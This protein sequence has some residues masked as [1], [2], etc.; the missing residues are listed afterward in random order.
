MT[1]PTRTWPEDWDAQ[2]AGAGCPFCAQGRIE[3]NEYGARFFAGRVSDAYLQRAGPARG[4]SIVVS[5]VGRHVPDPTEFTVAELTAFWIEVRAAATLIDAV[6][7]PAHLNYDLLGNSVPHVHVHIVPRYADDPAPGRPLPFTFDPVPPA[8]F[9][10]D[11]GKLREVASTGPVVFPVTHHGLTADMFVI[12][13]GRFLVLTRAGR[14]GGGVEYLPGGLVDPGEDPKDAAIRETREETGLE[15]TD[16]S[17]LRVWTYDVR[18]GWDTVHATYVGHAPEADV[19][20]T[21]EHTAYRWVTPQEYVD[22]W[23]RED[24]EESFPAFSGW[25]RHVR[26]NCGLVAELIGR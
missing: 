2:K 7:E 18:E 26:D 6:F 24:L 23:C 11:L 4:Y 1:N 20:I 5:R 14:L 13:D 16:V 22:Q 10:E 25:M 19:V 3:S 21:D 17:L 9:D 15:L 8:Q 12:R